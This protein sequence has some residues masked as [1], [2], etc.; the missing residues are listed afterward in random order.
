MP[1][2]RLN[3]HRSLSIGTIGPSSHFLKNRKKV[4]LMQSQC[5]VSFTSESLV[6]AKEMVALLDVKI[7]EFRLKDQQKKDRLL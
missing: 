4:V 7:E 3:K 5:T 6:I 2:G 1:S